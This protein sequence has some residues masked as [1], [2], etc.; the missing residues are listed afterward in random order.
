MS[1]VPRMILEATF[2][3]EAQAYL[4]G[5][6]LEH[7][8]ES[9]AQ[10]TQ[11]KIT[12]A[13]LELVQAQRPEFQVFNELL[14][15][16]RL[17]RDRTIHKVVPDNMVVVCPE[18]VRATTS[19]NL[20]LEPCPPWWTLEYVSNKNKRKDY[21]NN[22]VKYERELKVPYY[23]LFTPDALE[24]TLYRHGGRKYHSVKP[25]AHGR[26]ELAEQGLE[27]AMLG[28]WVRFWHNGELLP[29]PA[30]LER[31][32]RLTRARL[33]ETTERLDRTTQQLDQTSQRLEQTSQRLAEEAK[34]RQEMGKRLAD[35]ERQLD[36][37]RRDKPHGRAQPE[38]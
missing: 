35:M 27:V 2:E 4:R 34:L 29:L 37:A 32:L 36:Q 33:R 20:P 31:D 15:Q 5:L 16:Y 21:E 9:T 6:P 3:A 28:D 17:G 10:S 13:S 8:M 1:T 26:Y 22:M 11:R 19:F 7:F 14:V 12:L 38:R 30:D 18:K 24:V 23:L 25:N